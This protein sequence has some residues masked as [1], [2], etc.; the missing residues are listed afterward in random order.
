MFGRCLCTDGEPHAIDAMRELIVLSF[1]P[2]AAQHQS[3]TRFTPSTRRRRRQGCLDHQHAIAATWNR[4]PAGTRHRAGQDRRARR[5]HAPELR[6]RDAVIVFGG[7]FGRL[8]AA[9]RSRRR[10]PRLGGGAAPPPVVAEGDGL[11]ERVLAVPRGR[12]VRRLY[13]VQEGAGRL[14]RRLSFWRLFCGHVV[15]RSSLARS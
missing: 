1:S 4:T 6:P 9:R 12:V 14:R 5:G 11:L 7:C 3:L 15:T 10:R 13:V 8:S 2:S